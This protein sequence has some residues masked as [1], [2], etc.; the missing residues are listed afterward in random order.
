MKT[1]LRLFKEGFLS[2]VKSV[3][4]NKLRTFLSLFGITIGIFCIISVF[5]VLDWMEKSIRDSISSMGSNVVYIQKF[6]WSFDSEMKWWDIVKWPTVTMNEYQAIL[7]RS[8]KSEAV[9]F[10][11][12][13]S[14]RIKYKN[15]VAN[16]AVLAAVT[17][18]MEKVVLFEI[19]KGRYFSPFD[20][21]SGSNVAVLGAEVAERLFGD[22]DPVGKVITM[23]GGFKASVIGVLKE[24]GQGAISLSNLDQL[25]FIPMNFGR[26]FI[27]IRNRFVDSQMIV[28]AKPDVS[29]QELTDELT[30]IMRAARRLKPVEISNF[31][32][33]NSKMLS[34]GFDAVF[35][36]INIG[37]W[38]IGAFAILVGGFGIANIMFV[39]VRERTNI[40]G[41]QKALGAKRGFILQQFLTESVLLSLAGGILGLL[42]IFIGSLVINY[43]YELNMHLTFGNIVLA[44]TISGVIGVIAGYAPASSAA[45][46]NPVDAIGFSF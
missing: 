44:L 31:S 3:T 34:Q 29:V 5:T 26:N 33:N 18:D 2:A 28:K 38:I 21:L 43:L 11:I 46:M 19:D 25:T 13:K 45:R 39:S 12:A 17:D 23:A 30:M 32:I 7:K 6:P 42:M 37:G 8:T 24:E 16:D 10:L 36:G 4:V 40:I 35:K 22:T 41:I 14:D 15:N 9:S 1:R 27:N 20:Y